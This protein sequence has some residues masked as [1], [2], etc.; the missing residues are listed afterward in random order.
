MDAPSSRQRAAVSAI[1]SAVHGTCGFSSRMA[2]SLTRASRIIFFFINTNSYSAPPQDNGTE[3]LHRCGGV[4]LP[5]RALSETEAIGWD[6]QAGIPRM[7]AFESR[8]CPAPARQ[9][10]LQG[11]EGGWNKPLGWPP[12]PLRAYAPS[13]G[14]A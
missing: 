4:R 5:P 14:R 6:F 2:Y 13:S 9:A 7:P 11:L 8:L 1:S 12:P 10:R 3:S